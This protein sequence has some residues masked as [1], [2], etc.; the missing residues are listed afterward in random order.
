MNRR[1]IRTALFVSALAHGFAIAWIMLQPPPNRPP[2]RLEVTLTTPSV[3]PQRA[4]IPSEP[5]EGRQEDPVVPAEAKVPGLPLDRPQPLEDLDAREPERPMVLNLERPTDWDRWID[6]GAGSD[7]NAST[8]FL[9][10]NAALE[11]A[12]G[13]GIAARERRLLVAQRGAA[14]YGV[15]DSAYAREGP[16]GTELK[17]DGRC[18]TLVED[19]AVEAGARWW[20][21][22]CTDTRQTPFTLPPVGYD[23]LGRV[24]VD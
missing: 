12:L 21:T 23:R 18:V 24:V 2:V 14:L 4:E 10:F 6:P 15:A 7:Q 20:A 17:S 5:A 19:R 13:T 11:A 8:P 9:P 22:P 3:P 1:T 16:R